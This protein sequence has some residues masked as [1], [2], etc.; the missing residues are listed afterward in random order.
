[1]FSSLKVFVLASRTLHLTFEPG[2][3]SSASQQDSRRQEEISEYEGNHD[4]ENKSH[5]ESSLPTS[6]SDSILD[7]QEGSVGT[8]EETIRF[9][10]YY[11]PLHGLSSGKRLD[12]TSDF[13]L[14]GSV[15]PHPR[16]DSQT[17][18]DT[19][20]VTVARA[21]LVLVLTLVGNC[22]TL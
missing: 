13:I 9:G 22:A 19:R 5:G 18:Q 15:G 11:L 4:F 12:L 14:C 10:W 20:C 8:E 17:R 6:R 3:S 1:M 2:M 21:L 7:S 16:L